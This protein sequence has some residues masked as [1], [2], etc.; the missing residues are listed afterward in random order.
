MS[1]IHDA[2]MESNSL[3][4]SERLQKVKNPPQLKGRKK[5]KKD[6]ACA[7]EEIKEGIVTDAIEKVGDT[8][9]KVS[10]VCDAITEE[11]KLNEESYVNLEDVVSSDVYVESFRRRPRKQIIESMDTHGRYGYD[12]NA[13]KARR[14]S[15]YRK[16]AGLDEE[17]EITENNINKWAFDRT[18]MWENVTP[19]KLRAELLDPKN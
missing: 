15:T 19:D 12:P 16:F 13:R 3:E 5:S 10:K 11:K 18:C 4:E 2:I 17:F 8:A 6:S 14:I 1:F 7:T 9:E